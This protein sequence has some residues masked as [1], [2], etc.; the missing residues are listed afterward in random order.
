MIAL[1]LSTGPALQGSTPPSGGCADAAGDRRPCEYAGRPLIEALDDLRARG[2]NLIFSSDLVRPDMIVE[3]EPPVAAPRQVLDRLL[4]AFGLEARDGPAGTVLV[5]RTT[6]SERVEPGRDDPPPV[7]S[8]PALRERVRVGASST[9]EPAPMTT[10][11]QADIERLPAVGADPTRS[12]A[13]LPGIVSADKSAQLSIR[14]GGSDEAL[15]ILDGLEIEEPFH[16]KD[17]LAFSSIVDAGAIGRIDV[18]TGIFPAEY[19]DRMSGVIDLT[20]ADPAEAE[21]TAIGLSLINASL[22]S[23][24]G[25]GDAGGSWLI[26]ARSWFPDAVLDIVDPGGEDISP[27]YNDLLGKMQVRLA[28]GSLLSAHVLAS[29]DDLDFQN[30]RGDT[31]VLA[32]DDHRYVWINWKT[33]WTAR[34]Y[35]QTVL[36][37]SGVVRSRR[38][39]TLDDAGSSAQVGD[40]RSFGSVGAKQDWIFAAG[41]RASLKWGFDA[42]RLEAEYVYRSHVEQIDPLAGSG[43]SGGTA[44]AAVIDRD[45][46]LEPSGAEFGAYVA[47]QFRVVP[48]LTVDLG[49][50]R[51]RQTLTGETETSPRLNLA[52]APGEGSVL[53]AGWGR[54]HQPQGI[55]ELQIED[56]VVDFLP[57]QRA[58]HWELDLDHRFPGGMNLGVSAYV[59]GMTRLRPRYEN[60]FNPVQLFPEA[61]P[62]RVRIAPERALARGVEIGLGQD[63]GRS[64]SWRASYALAST[65]DRIDGAWVPRSVDQRHTLNL[66]LSYRRGERWQ[67]SLAGVYHTGWPTTEVRAEQ[68]QNPDGSLAIQPILGPRNALRYPPYHRVDLRV[69]RRYEL[70]GGTLALHLDVTNLFGHDN[71]CCVTDLQYLV[72]PD[73]S[74]RVERTEG[75]WLR[76]LPVVGLTWDF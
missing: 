27:S 22:L 8:R 71:V 1:L 64:L 24:G 20:T 9:G 13:W 74:V 44:A 19:G 57:A 58:E 36:S 14:G 49:V 65:Q 23:G 47:G 51:D 63:R 68:A 61:E 39:N 69:A 25:R 18:L 70:G 41:E 28:G 7:H 45:L 62:D 2:L 35:A 10:L 29:R 43:A 31:E 59:K 16:L 40:A 46:T 42:R 6:A 67:V 76:Q 34:L 21:R 48:Q 32:G 50:R 33:P 56:G 66:S 72:Q 3:A 52:W 75:H 17:F 37:S 26:S 30:D 5:V 11:N 15:V 4:G 54:F 55:N 73:G 53:R 12:I 38:G 60:L